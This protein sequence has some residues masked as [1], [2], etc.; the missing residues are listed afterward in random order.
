MDDSQLIV[1]RWL[2]IT[3][4]TRTV[5]KW[6]YTEIS[7]FPKQLRTQPV[8]PTL[9]SMEGGASTGA[10]LRT[11]APAGLGSLAPTV[12]TVSTPAPK[13]SFQNSIS[14]ATAKKQ[15]AQSVFSYYLNLTYR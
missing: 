7:S 2:L 3:L 12:S 13:Q 14:R 15:M 1:I 6:G 11:H 9:A 8:P 4:T 5:S 10:R